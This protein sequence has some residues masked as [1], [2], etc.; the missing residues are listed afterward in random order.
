MA[1]ARG[2]PAVGRE[3]PV[4][5]NV[6]RPDDGQ[7]RAAPPARGAGGRR[8]NLTRWLSVEKTRLPGTGRYV[9]RGVDEREGR[10]RR[11]GGSATGC[12]TASCGSVLRNGSLPVGRAPTSGSRLAGFAARASLPDLG[13]GHH[14]R[15]NSNARC[16]GLFPSKGGRRIAGQTATEQPSAV[17]SAQ[18]WHILGCLRPHGGRQAL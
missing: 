11:R 1:T 15:C 6:G 17:V 9:E 18:L 10:K 14:S 4:R 2:R 3:G 12:A 5:P 16:R 8:A 13:D 7:G